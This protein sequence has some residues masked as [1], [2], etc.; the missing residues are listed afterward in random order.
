MAELSAETT[1]IIDRLK[2]EG[3]LVRNSGTNSLRQ[4][5]IK[6]DKFDGIFR[7]IN[8]NVIE[9]TTLM[10]KQMGLATDAAE[11]A[12]TQ[13]QFEEVETPPQKADTSAEDKQKAAET[14]KKIDE[15]GDSIAKALTMK[16]LAIGAA[17]GFV[18]YNLL[19][20]FID[21]K[22]NGAFTEMEEGIALLGPKLK[23]FSETGFE[24]IQTTMTNIEQK[25]QD[26]AGPDGQLQQ[27]N[28]N[29]AELNEKIKRILD[30]G[31]SD[32]LLGLSGITAALATWRVGMNKI[33]KLQNQVIDDLDKQ[34]KKNA[35]TT[36]GQSKLQSALGIGRKLQPGE[37]PY[38]QGSGSPSAGTQPKASGAATGTTSTQPQRV[39]TGSPSAG[40]QSGYKPG[41]TVQV[42]SGA[43]VPKT[44]LRTDAA[45]SGKFTMG[46]D[47]RL[48]GPN[49]GTF[50]SDKAALEAMAKTLDPK[51]SKVFNRLVQLF[52]VLKIAA[53]LYLMYEIY[54]ILEDDEKYPTKESK[55]I[56]IGPLVGN[57]VGG[58]AGVKIGAAIGSIPPLTGWGTLIGGVVVGIAG[59]FA[60]GWVGEKVARWAFS[61][62]VKEKDLEDISQMQVRPMPTGQSKR[63]WKKLYG[64]THNPDGTPKVQPNKTDQPVN[65]QNSI[66]PQQPLGPKTF[67]NGMGPL[68]PEVLK[69]MEQSGGTPG[70]GLGTLYME[71]SEGQIPLTLF[72]PNRP[73][74]FSLAANGQT[75]GA[76]NIFSAPQTTS[77]PVIVQNGGSDVTQIAV[78]GGGGGMSDKSTTVYNITGAI[79]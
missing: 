8:T 56:A 12:R 10:Q 42:A 61:E 72:K 34:N 38:R 64:K 31:W 22:Y 26:F 58:I 65:K 41:P 39:G 51:Y 70:G 54:S 75:G 77:S 59:S 79:N 3:D 19:K 78:G 36:A 60:G 17:G 1:A 5:N 43:Q 6:L 27:M 53:A 11:R 76:V 23:G 71:S 24:N 46:A 9:Q 20:G 29:L 50:A 66:N 69:Q 37:N 48:R 74:Q 25:Y 49:G 4:M 18:G 57:I 33:N 44:E 7:S 52:S 35:R 14:N 68:S 21:E 2:A 45:K 15:I 73:M 47:G 28:E 32:L 63:A 40:T 16:N 62:E 55:I 13:E 30:F 67:N